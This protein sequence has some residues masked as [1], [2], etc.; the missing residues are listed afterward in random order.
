MSQERFIF[1][2][3]SIY[4]IEGDFEFEYKKG[5]RIY[6]PFLELDL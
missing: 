6:Y 2:N 3:L 1:V 4:I 5:P